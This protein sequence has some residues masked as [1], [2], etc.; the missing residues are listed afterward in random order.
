MTPSAASLASR[1]ADL[2]GDEHV[3][4]D[5]AILAEYRV[6]GT[7]PAAALRPGSAAEIAEILRFAAAERLAVI[8]MGGRTKLGIGMPP[9]RYDLALDLGRMNRM[10]AYDPAD[11]TLG[12]EPGLRFADLAPRLAAE[13]QFLPLAPA[14]ADRATI[15]GIAAAGADSPLRRSLGRTRDYLLGMEFVTG[16]GVAA[17]SGGRVVKNVTGYDLHKLLVGSLGTLAV[18]TRLNFRTFPLPAERRMFV[19]A[20]ASAAGALGLCGALARSQLQPMLVEVAN[21][22]AARFLALGGERVPRDQWSVIV[23]AAGHAALVERHAREF[24]QMAGEEHAAEFASMEDAAETTLLGA[25]SEFPRT[26]LDSFPEAAI[27]RIAVLPTAM[28]G[29]IDQ[30]SALADRYGFEAAILVRVSSV[31]YAALLRLVGATDARKNLQAVC[32][33]L[34]DVSQRAGAKPMIEWCPLE[35]KRG[36]S[37]WPPA[38]DELEITLRLKKVLDPQGI[39]APGRFQGGL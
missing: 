7:E 22:V 5:P 9:Q 4:S 6:D 12:V 25:I 32:R 10:L 18:I 20:F 1:L 37:V 24:K 27:F 13:R 17:K 16:G 15:G 14:F 30:I 39:L 21:P 29:L 2:V 35:A 19:V 31:I 23:G 33:E 26:V 8:P 36:M 11:L 28:V 38:G 34:M 3:A